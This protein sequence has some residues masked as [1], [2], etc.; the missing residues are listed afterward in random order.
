[1][2]LRNDTKGHNYFTRR[3]RLRVTINLGLR[4]KERG[5]QY[6]GVYSFKQVINSLLK[7]LGV[8]CQMNRK[9]TGGLGK[10]ERGF[11]KSL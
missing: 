9:V 6:C 2:I 10:V 7:T 1:M 8:G 3:N 11:G 5:E 4:R